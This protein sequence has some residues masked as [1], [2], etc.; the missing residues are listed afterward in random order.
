MRHAAPL[1]DW[2]GY[3][4]GAVVSSLCDISIIAMNLPLAV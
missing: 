4:L 1:M 2:I 3:L